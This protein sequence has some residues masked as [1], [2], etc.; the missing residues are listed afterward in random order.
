MSKQETKIAVF[1]AGQQCRRH[2]NLSATDMQKGFMGTAIL[3]G[4]LSNKKSNDDTYQLAACVRSSQSADR[5][6]RDLAARAAR[7]DIAHGPEAAMHVAKH[8]DI[9]LLGCAP[10]DL[11]VMLQ[12]PGLA[13]A[14]MGKI[15]ISMLAGVSYEQLVAAFINVGVEQPRLVRILP[16]LGAKIGDSV[17]L[18]ATSRN[19]NRESEHIRAVDELLSCIG[20]VQYVPE[21]QMIEA[22]AVG[23]L[24]HALAIVAIDT[25][26]DASAAEG[27]PRPTALLLVQRCLRSATGLLLS[28]MSPEEMK[29]AMAI[30]TGITINSVLQLEKGARP[31]IAEGARAAVAYTRKMAE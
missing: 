3:Q 17:T 19:N 27:L 10:N 30:P 29:N 20:T 28:G 1:G 31:A 8:A 9:V 5:L 12:L 24:T 11:G 21:T 25:L 26:G 14:L 6:R 22:T 16:T 18:V 7:V 15:V 4:L 23:A 13:A 2:L